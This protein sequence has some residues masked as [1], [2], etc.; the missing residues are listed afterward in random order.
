MKKKINLLIK[1]Y[2][3]SFNEPHKKKPY[4][5]FIEYGSQSF[6]FSNKDKAKRFLVQFQNESTA[7]Y[8]ELGNFL[9]D[10]YK[11]NI[12]LVHLLPR[13]DY[14]SILK[15]LNTLTSRYSFILNTKTEIA[16]GRE[17]DLIYYEL[18]SIYTIYLAFLSSN[19]RSFY[20][21]KELKFNVKSLKRLRKDLDF[22]LSDSDGIEKLTSS[23]IDTVLFYRKLSIV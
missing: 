1:D 5:L 19:N 14:L 11:T 12:S 3:D 10:C 13:A 7:L 2:R 4:F 6:T 18:K 23:K 15:R 9:S 17:I 16:I 8:K 22:L 20:L 21:L